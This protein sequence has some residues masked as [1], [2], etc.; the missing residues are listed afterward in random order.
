MSCSI[1]RLRA[2]SRMPCVVSKSHMMKFLQVVTGK[3]PT[4]EEI[5]T[6]LGVPK[7]SDLYKQF[8]LSTNPSKDELKKLHASEKY[9]EAVREAT[10]NIVLT[11]CRTIRETL[12]PEW[13]HKDDIVGGIRATGSVGVILT[14]V[15][16]AQGETSVLKIVRESPHD[17]MT[18]DQEVAVQ[19]LMHDAGIAPKV[20]WH[21]T[22]ETDSKLHGI[23]SGAMAVT[24]PRL[25]AC[26][27]HESEG[28]DTTQRIA[29]AVRVILTQLR[30]LKFT[31]GDLHVYNMMVDTNGQLL[32]IDFGQSSCSSNVTDVDVFQL[33][34]S[35][36]AMRAEIG[37]GAV[38]ALTDVCAEFAGEAMRDVKPS[39]YHTK[40]QSTHA[41]YRANI[42]CDKSASTQ[43]ATRVS[44]ATP[45]TSQQTIVTSS[46]DSST[47]IAPSDSSSSPE[48]K[49]AEKEMTNT[50]IDL[51]VD[52]PSAKEA[53][54]KRLFPVVEA[55]ETTAEQAYE[56][57][58]THWH[59]VYTTTMKAT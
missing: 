9:L 54:R 26:T 51:L 41:S 18:V 3:T 50:A 14:L 4:Q 1:G 55:K 33:L 37:Q 49:K 17:F 13:L 23:R 34:R 38:I 12:P 59:R 5:R 28:D 27:S 7:P 36:H 24:L 32:L 53:V 45:I 2:V 57:T 47:P 46:F 52:G 42:G 31:H 21:R 22:S 19:N 40:W 6:A 25:L 58:A 39:Q 56:R 29:S 20:E 8:G 30:D 10:A 48:V 11:A 35:V 16:P 15:R 44:T 43:A